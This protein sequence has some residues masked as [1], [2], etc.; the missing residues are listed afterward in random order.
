MNLGR[1]SNHKGPYF[2]IHFGSSNCCFEKTPL[3]LT[4]QSGQAKTALSHL[5]R[6]AVKDLDLVATM[7]GSEAERVSNDKLGV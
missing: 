1:E 6:A 7:K 3:L 2:G 5:S 4:S